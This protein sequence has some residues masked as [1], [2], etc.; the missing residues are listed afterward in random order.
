MTVSK[1]LQKPEEL[2]TKDDLA[3]LAGCVD[4]VQEL[5]KR[6]QKTEARKRKLE[7]VIDEPEELRRKI[8]LLA[9]AIQ[10]AQYPVIYSGAGIST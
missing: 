2:R 6:K 10:E 1:I 4:T 8:N 3:V 5:E 9:A 7:E